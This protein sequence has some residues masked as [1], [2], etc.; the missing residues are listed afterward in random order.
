MTRRSWSRSGHFPLIPRATRRRLLTQVF[1]SLL[2]VL[3]L[4]V[5]NFDIHLIFYLAIILGLLAFLMVLLVEE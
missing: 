5:W 2:T 3:L 1:F 4:I